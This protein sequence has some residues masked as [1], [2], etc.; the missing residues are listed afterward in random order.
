MPGKNSVLEM[1][2][3]ILILKMSH[4]VDVSSFDKTKMKKQQVG[5]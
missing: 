1:K 4:R 5:S 2:I 3:T